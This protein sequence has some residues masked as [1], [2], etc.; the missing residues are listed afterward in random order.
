ML[1]LT[2]R[3]AGDLCDQSHQYERERK[4]GEEERTS[5]RFPPFFILT[6]LTFVN[7]SCVPGCFPA[8]IM[9]V[10]GAWSVFCERNSK[11][12]RREWAERGRGAGEVV[13]QNK[14]GQRSFVKV[15]TSRLELLRTPPAPASPSLSPEGLPSELG[16]MKSS[17][18]R[19]S[20]EE[21]AERL[22]RIVRRT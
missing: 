19:N 20:T 9:G 8:D 12:R 1:Y 2:R 18:A 21:R 13:N 15:V 3:T 10:G 4:R 17:R 16:E 22:R 11:G 7:F 14:A 6:T 5:N